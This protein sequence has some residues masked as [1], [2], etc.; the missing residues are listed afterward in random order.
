[1]RGRLPPRRWGFRPSGW[2]YCLLG[3]IIGAALSR[4]MPLIPMAAGRP[5]L[6]EQ[7][8]RRP[9]LPEGAA[10][11]QVAGTGPLAQ[12]YLLVTAAPGPAAV[13]L[14]ALHQVMAAAAPGRSFM[15][16]IV[17]GNDLPDLPVAV[18]VHLD[19]REGDR[20]EFS[21][22]SAAGGALPVW[23]HQV[24]REALLAEAVPIREG[25]AAEFGRLSRSRARA[26]LPPAVTL[27]GV[28]LDDIDLLSLGQAAER[29]LIALD[30]LPS[31]P[32]PRWWAAGRSASL[33]LA[34][35]GRYAPAPVLWMIQLIW[36]IPLAA[37]VARSRRSVP[38]QRVYLLA[39]DA[40]ILKAVHDH[41]LRQG[42]IPSL[43]GRRR[44]R[45]HRR[46]GD[47]LLPAMSREAAI[48]LLAAGGLL[49]AAGVSRG[50]PAIAAAGL[51]AVPIA[52]LVNQLAGRGGLDWPQRHRGLQALLAL[53]AI[54]LTG[55]T[56]GHPFSLL[57]LLPAL[58]AWPA[59][60]PA[61]RARNCVLAGTGAAGG[62]V[63]AGMNWPE[64]L[65]GPAAPALLIVASLAAVAFRLA[66]A[67]HVEGGGERWYP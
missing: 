10:N 17:Q 29:L 46:P 37:A 49:L 22:R 30:G 60:A 25:L 45:R 4:P 26:G 62:M 34:A 20:V 15:L 48:G 55:W 57:A 21:V 12:E 31:L 28:G 16:A 33:Y 18:H 58:L 23:L 53:A 6:G 52:W 36:L 61:Q 47:G 59:L 64:A 35:G 24:A 63:L 65:G 50:S 32:E 44:A 8:I 41:R 3:L 9:P 56:G 1:M 54:T 14:P 40:A 19:Y 43:P 42:R 67:G 27:Q 39:E 11:W 66:L 5:V 38:H 7:H 51:L 2:V 13:L